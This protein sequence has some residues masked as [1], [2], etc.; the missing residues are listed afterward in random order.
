M[1]TT[2]WIHRPTILCAIACALLVAGMTGAAAAAP[3]DPQAAALVQERYYGSFGEPEP[4]TVPQSPAPSDDTPWLPIAL[5]IGAA[6][7]VVTASA[8]QLRR[9]RVRRRRAARVAT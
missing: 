7:A 1:F 2:R 5:V 9:L 4:L 6:L 8:A 3:S